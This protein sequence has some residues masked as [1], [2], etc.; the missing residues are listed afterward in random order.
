MIRSNI[1]DSSAK[2][3]E[4]VYTGA[5]NNDSYEGSLPVSMLSGYSS[6]EITELSGNAPNS[7]LWIGTNSTLCCTASG[8]TSWK[9]N[10]SFP[11]TID[12]STLPSGTQTL[13][14]RSQGSTTA[15]DF[16]VTLIP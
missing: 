1:I 9:E 16:K 12:L 13:V 14:Y 8:S 7:K 10:V 15:V 3:L 11:L 5:R 6:M 2:P 4:I